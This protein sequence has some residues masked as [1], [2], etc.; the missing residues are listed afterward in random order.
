MCQHPSTVL[1]LLCHH[2]LPKNIDV[3]LVDILT[4]ALGPW[5]G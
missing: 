5:Q 2:S 4:M 1:A 3:L